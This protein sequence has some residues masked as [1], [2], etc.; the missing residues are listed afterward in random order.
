MYGH[1]LNNEKKKKNMS[2]LF[3]GDAHLHHVLGK[4]TSSFMVTIAP[5]RLH[6]AP[7]RVQLHRQGL[8]W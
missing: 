7:C 1:V 6:A 2:F 8:F 5:H 4:L 3:G